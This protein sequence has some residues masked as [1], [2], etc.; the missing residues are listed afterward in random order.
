MM[1]TLIISFYAIYA[2]VM[3]SDPEVRAL[4]CRIHDEIEAYCIP[5]RSYPNGIE[6]LTMDCCNR[7]SKIVEAA[8]ISTDECYE[9]WS[10][11]HEKD[12]MELI[13]SSTLRIKYVLDYS[14]NHLAHSR[15]LQSGCITQ[16]NSH[17]AVHSV[18]II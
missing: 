17:L 13:C 8:N 15:Q 9:L 14:Y 2:S 5:S 6:K 10:T 3:A 4:I 16:K 7:F 12:M 18:I 11:L 1:W